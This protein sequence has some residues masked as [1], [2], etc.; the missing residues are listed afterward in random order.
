MK[1]CTEI[2]VPDVITHANLVTIGSGV[3][4]RVGV[5]YPHLRIVH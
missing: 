1:F 5:E 3:L 4:G 2:G